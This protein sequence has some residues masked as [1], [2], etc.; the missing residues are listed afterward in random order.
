MK[1]T[2]VFSL[3]FFLILFKCFSFP[4]GEEIQKLYPTLKY[5]NFSDFNVYYSEKIVDLD[6]DEY[7]GTIL[8][9]K[10]LENTYIVFE[11]VHHSDYIIIF[12]DNDI[13]F[14]RPGNTIIITDSG[15]IYMK[16]EVVTGGR[17]YSIEKFY[18]ENGEIHL[19]QQPFY[20]LGIKQ[21]ANV[22]FTILY[23]PN[24]KSSV[25]AN[26]AKDTEVEVIGVK[27]INDEEWILIK[28]GLE[29]TGWVKLFFIEPWR[30]NFQRAFLDILSESYP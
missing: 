3:L 6:V 28:S 17:I 21:N 20:Y 1:K 19:V 22:P 16:Y 27:F 18:I 12:K 2:I 30:A 9:F 26:I 24:E 10:N 25:V 14:D 13:L 7:K 11:G 23:E 4:P 8:K 29:L 5:Y 15:Y